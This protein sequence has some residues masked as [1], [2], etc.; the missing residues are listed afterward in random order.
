MDVGLEDA[1]E[2]AL[3]VIHQEHGGLV[4]MEKGAD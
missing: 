3:K 2:G 1:L 4:W